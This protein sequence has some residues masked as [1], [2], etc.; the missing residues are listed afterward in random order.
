VDQLERGRGLST[1]RI[2]AVRQAL[3]RAESASGA[4]RT[5][6][7]R[8]LAQ[9]LHGDMAGSNDGAKVHTLANAID[10]LAGAR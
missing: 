6:A 9:S 7:L 8:Q 5:T 10:Q 2:A 4:A 3:Q 1:A